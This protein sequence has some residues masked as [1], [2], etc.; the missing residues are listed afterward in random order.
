MRSCDHCSFCVPPTFLLLRKRTALHPKPSCLCSLHL[1][2]SCFHPLA[3]SESTRNFK[4]QPLWDGYR[5]PAP[6]WTRSSLEL[7]GPCT[8]HLKILF[9]FSN[10]DVFGFFC[11]L[12]WLVITSSTILNRAGKR[13][14]SFAFFPSNLHTPVGCHYWMWCF[15]PQK[16]LIWLMNFTVC[17]D[18]HHEWNIGF[19]LSEQY[20]AYHW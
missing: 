10:P 8:H 12:N 14:G 11:L 6:V 16:A 19:W 9:C 1:L 7:Y 15:F 5:C 13:E 18:F 17:C 3:T 20:W 2:C 4:T